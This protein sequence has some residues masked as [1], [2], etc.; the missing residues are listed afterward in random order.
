M[1]VILLSILSSLLGL[2]TNSY[3]AINA[4]LMHYGYYAIFLLMTLEYAS[5]PIPS[6]IVL[7]LI[8]FFAAKG[9]FDFLLALI[10]VLISG[11]VGM[12]IDYYIAYFVGKDVVYKHLEFFHVSR[13][14]IEQ[15]DDWF[16]RNGSF[17]VFVSRMIPIARGLVSFPAG[18][19]MMEKRKF[20]L[21]ST[22]GALIWDVALMTFGYYGL[23]SSNISI[24]VS[25]VAVFAVAIYVIYKLGIAQL[26]SRK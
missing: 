1:S 22:L 7:P 9:T 12:A 19:A 10:V 23:A 2:L 5:M 25:A 24:V 20:F 18:F 6:E 26:K 3:G 14:R 13:E 15:F 11:I 4:L 16:N 21:Y 17:A 8:G